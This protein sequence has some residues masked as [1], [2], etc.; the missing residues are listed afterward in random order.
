MSKAFFSRENTRSTL[1]IGI[2]ADNSSTHFNHYDFICLLVPSRTPIHFLQESCRSGTFQTL[3][4][5]ILQES[6]ISDK[7]VRFLQIRHFLQIQ[8]FLAR[9]L[10]VKT[11]LARFLDGRKCL[12]CT[13]NNKAFF[14][15]YFEIQT[16]FP[17]YSQE[18]GIFFQDIS[19]IRDFL[20]SY[21]QDQAFSFKLLPRSGIF[22]QV[23]PRS[24]IFFQVTSKI[25]TFLA[26]S[27]KTR[28][29][30]PRSSKIPARI[31]H[32]LPRS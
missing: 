18:S 30:L 25:H 2:G 23:L 3:S 15:I 32:C 28:H 22:F 17:S 29:F 5:R 19:K 9:F 6:W 8:T 24:D 21:F 7:P 1:T 14:P 20:P 4:A 16:L 31:M 27:C 13:G 10:Q 26:R 11:F 12:E